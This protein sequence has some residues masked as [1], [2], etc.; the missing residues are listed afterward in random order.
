MNL[1]SLFEPEEIV[2]NAWHNF[3]SG[4]GEVEGHPDAAVTLTAVRPAMAMLFRSLGGSRSVEITEA[5][6]VPIEGRQSWWR[7][8]GR[9]RDMEARPS[10][11]GEKLRVPTEIDAFPDP[12]LNRASY[13]WLA[14]GAALLNRVEFEEDDLARIQGDPTLAYL[15]VNATVA[16]IVCTNCLGLAVTYRKL[17]KASL[18]RRPADAANPTEQVVQCI[19]SGGTL[20][21]PVS[22]AMDIVQPIPFWFDLAGLRTEELLP[23]DEEDAPAPSGLAETKKK[24]GN[25]RDLDQ[26]KRKDSFIIHRFESILSWVESMNINRSVDDD[27]ED[28]AKKA[29]D[30]QDNVTL[31]QH[32]R[33]AATRL[34]LHL[35]LSPAEADH[36]RLSDEY[37][38]PEWNFR[39]QAYL[40]DHV[41]VLEAQVQHQTETPVFQPDRRL[42]NEVRRQFETLLPRRQLLPRQIDGAELDLDAVIANKANLTA[43]GRG[44]NRIYIDS[45]QIDR[46]ICV[47]I[48]VDTSRST[49]AA[50]GETCVIDVAKSA[51]AALAGGIDVSGD[52]LGIWGFS[53][54]RRDRVFI[55]R[56]KGFDTPL[57][58]GVIDNIGAL[59]PSHYTRLGAAIR[60]V[61]TKLA[62]ETSALRLLLVI[63]DGKPNDIDHYEGQHGIEDSHM[64]VREARRQDIV[65]HSVIVDEDGQDW[66]ARIFGKGGFTLLPHPSRLTSALPQIYRTLTQET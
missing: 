55:S 62:E 19:L 3:V 61:T 11:N 30:D 9:G 28:N 39:S 47:A 31:T 51:L 49:E 54:L 53:S 35:D 12:D 65:L 44:S 29:A 63:T 32:D 48:L 26:T 10:Y 25:R 46:D 58:Q 38:Y 52:R 40:P 43:T 2:G 45:R 41:R 64:A 36:I 42:M 24:L 7:L 4:K 27:D 37:T 15:L 18:Q 6:S 21:T 20:N 5:P 66:F 50:I 23:A 59:R 13:L 16:P 22:S 34:R 56:A 8:A 57:S 14:A 60:H 33:K 1:L 17:C